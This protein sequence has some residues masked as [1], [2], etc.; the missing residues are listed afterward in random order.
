[1]RKRRLLFA[2][3]TMRMGDD[4]RAA[5]LFDIIVNFHGSHFCTSM[6]AHGSLWKLGEITSTEATNWLPR[7]FRGSRTCTENTS[8]PWKPNFHVLPPIY[9]LLPWKFVS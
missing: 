4:R 9:K 8:L 7:H 5:T 6:E 1:M 2:G 3:R